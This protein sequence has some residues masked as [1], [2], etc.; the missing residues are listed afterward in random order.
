[1][2]NKANGS[3]LFTM[4]CRNNSIG[5]ACSELLGMISTNKFVFHR[6]TP[7]LLLCVN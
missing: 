6:N 2:I 4:R 7:H 5:E 1:M 3:N